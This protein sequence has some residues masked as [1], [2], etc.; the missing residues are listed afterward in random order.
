MQLSVTRCLAISAMAGAFS[1]QLMA[2]EAEAQQPAQSK[3]LR[4]Q[5]SWPASTTLHE[6][7]VELAKRIE[8]LTAGRVK[9]NASAAGQVVPAFETLDATHKRV[10]DGSHTW[11]GYWVGKNKAAILFTGGPAG[12]FGM[13]HMD[14]LSWMWHGGGLERYHKFYRETLKLDVIAFPVIS[15]SPQALGWF[16]NEIKSLADFKGQ[17][18]R[19]TGMAAEIYSEMGMRTVNMPGGEIMPAA[20]RGTIDCAEFVGGIEDLRFGFHTIWKNHYAPAL[21]ENTSIGELLI[22]TTAW[23]ELPETDREVIKAAMTE[24]LFVGWAKWQRQNAEAL[25]ELK[26]KHKVNVRQTP[27]EIK[28]AFM[29]AWDRIAAR[30]A[31]KNPVFKELYDDLKKWASVTVPAKR[32]YYPAYNLAADHYWPQQTQ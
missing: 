1:F 2:V 26:D 17:K 11:A 15:T 29:E 13:D 21:H 9:V 8:V 25:V 12:P 30:E 27:A 19:Q 10:I 5:S 18:C 14:Y 3:M 6:N 4:I 16:K 32:F 31:E 20:E 7:F 22:N 28:K 24:R 23:N